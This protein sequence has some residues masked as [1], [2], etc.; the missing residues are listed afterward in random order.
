MVFALV[1]V[2]IERGILGDLDYYPATNNPYDFKS[3][4]VVVPLS[5]LLMG[6]LFGTVEVLYLGRVFSRVSFGQKIVF[7]SLI[8]L[9]V[10]SLFLMGVSLIMSSQA[11][12]LP[13]F[14]S[15]VIE[16][17]VE[18]ATNLAF[19]SIAAFMGL[20]I[21]V[22]LFLLEV[23]DNLGQGVLRNF[24]SGKYHHPREEE[25]IF[26]FMDMKSSTTIAERIGHVRYF[27]LQVEY[28][29]DISE[30]ILKTSGTI[31]QYVGD[32]VVVSWKLEE[33]LRDNNCIRCFL[34]A[35][36][37]ITAQREKY[38]SQFDQIP[39]FKAGL[40]FGLATTGELGTIKK[41]IVYSGDVLNTTA[42]IQENC[43][44]LE[45]DL[46]VSGQLLG[47]LQLGDNYQVEDKGEISLR[48]RDE[49]VKLYGVGM[50]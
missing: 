11:L 3:G 14:H 17:M 34:L 8:Y 27:E 46:L 43:K 36:E 7:K 13:L 32:E 1:Y 45:E 10:I 37:I 40:H 39:E 2:L 44:I 38:R 31:Y 30:A 5:S 35:K 42:R 24:L 29:R 21:A 25:L 9:V 4:L 6:W 18:F 49:A 22:S 47:R 23:S 20:I 50:L 41:E 15:R 12:D 48:G 16:A 33:G 28:Y 26:M 19:L